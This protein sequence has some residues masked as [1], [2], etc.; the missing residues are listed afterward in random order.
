MNETQ[1]QENQTATFKNSYSESKGTGV[2][3]T[4][5]FAIIVFAAMFFIAMY[6]GY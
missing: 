6:K 4:L 3:S 1:T 2:I 5:I